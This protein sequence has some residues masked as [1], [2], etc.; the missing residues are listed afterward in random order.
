MSSYLDDVL[1]RHSLVPTFAISLA[2]SVIFP[3]LRQWAHRWVND[4]YLAGSVAKGTG[5]SGTTDLDIFIS[6]HPD[7]PHTLQ[8]IYDRLFG[9]A[10]DHHWM[11]RRQNVSIGISF[12]GAKIDLVPGRL[13]HGF[14][15]YHSLWKN[16]ASTWTQTAPVIHIA[17]VR[18]SGRTREIRAIKIWRKN[19][20]LDF[21]SFYLELT[22]LDALAGCGW[23]L[24]NNVQ[25][26]LAYIAENLPTARVEDPANTNNVIS[27]DLTHAEKLAIAAQAQVSHDERNWTRT[28]W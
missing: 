2:E 8:E 14:I 23:N 7:T 13:Q 16:K 9:W 18:D 10:S 3:S 25:R 19:H 6:L 27:D 12:L 17:K 20:G 4:I 28:L 1:V 22:V 26:A 21:P 24:A 5:I 15:Y 11:P